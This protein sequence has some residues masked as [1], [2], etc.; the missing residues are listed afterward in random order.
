MFLTT[1]PLLILSVCFS[2]QKTVKIG[3]SFAI[4]KGETAKI[5]NADLQLKMI[6]SGHSF[7][8]GGDAPMCEVEI[9]SKAD[10]KKITLRIGKTIVQGNLIVKL[11]QV[12]TTANPNAADP[13]SETSCR[14][15][16]TKK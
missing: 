8:E 11:Q 7:G 13:W 2:I 5:K 1:L 10:T 4:K 15:V 14:F 9:R 6:S 3:E 12:G 16:V